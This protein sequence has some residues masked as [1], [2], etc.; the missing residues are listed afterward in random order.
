[1]LRALPWWSVGVEAAAWAGWHDAD[2]Y[3]QDRWRL[4]SSPVPQKEK[5]GADAPFDPAAHVL[6][7]E[8]YA[9]WKERAGR[10]GD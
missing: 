9:E 2:G 7:S 10:E 4:V 3:D 8:G 6:N 5:A 1:M